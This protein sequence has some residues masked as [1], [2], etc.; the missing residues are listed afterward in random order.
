MKNWVKKSGRTVIFTRDMSWVNNSE[1]ENELRNKARTNDLIICLPK[2]TTLTQSLKDDGAEIYTYENLNYT[3]K[4][5]FTFI[6][7]GSNSCKVAI[8]RKDEKHNHYIT[9]YTTKDTIE[10]YLAEDLVNIIKRIS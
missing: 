8:G 9:E 10:Y 7:Y 4:S 1:I 5:R 2:I 3:P 6:N